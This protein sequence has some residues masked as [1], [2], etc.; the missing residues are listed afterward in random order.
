ML[1]PDAKHLLARSFHLDWTSHDRPTFVEIDER[2][3]VDTVITFRSSDLD[4]ASVEFADEPVASTISTICE[5]AI[6]QCYSLIW[7]M[8]YDKSC[9]QTVAKPAQASGPSPPSL[10]HHA[11]RPKQPRR[12]DVG[13]SAACRRPVFVIEHVVHIKRA[14]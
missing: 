14:M 8:Y 1:A 2:N 7:C 11:P 6:V 5:S 3:Q 9:K 12:A 10:T 13:I 4:S